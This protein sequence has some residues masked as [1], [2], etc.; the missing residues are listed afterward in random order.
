MIYIDLTDTLLFF[1]RKIR[2]KMPII[3]TGITRVVLNFTYYGLKN[4]KAQ[5][6]YFSEKLQKYASIPN[7]SIL[8]LCNGDYQ[9]LEYFANIDISSRNLLRIKV[10]YRHKHLKFFVICLKYGVELLLRKIKYIYFNKTFSPVKFQDG[11]KILFLCAP[12]ILRKAKYLK[13]IK[14]E[15]KLEMIMLVHDIMPITLGDEYFQSESL[16][17]ETEFFLK[18]SVNFI[19]GFLVATNYW[20]DTLQKYLQ[21]PSDPTSNI[22][23]QVIKF[24][25]G[26]EK[27]QNII[28]CPV[29]GKFIMIVS[30]IEIRKNHIGL[31]KAWKILKDKGVIQNEKLVIIGK[32]GWKI[33]VLQEFL[34]TTHNVDGSVVVLNNVTNEQLVSLYTNCLFTVFPSFAEGYGL[35]IV[36]SFFYGKL[37]LTSNTTAMPEVGGALAEYMDPYNVYDIAEK[38]EKYTTDTNLL[39]TKNKAL[40]NIK[41]TSWEEASELLYSKVLNNPDTLCHGYD[42]AAAPIVP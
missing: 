28:P 34:N 26:N 9:G 14:K 2:K 29:E 24:G 37:C 35:P 42:S 39:N 11:D 10:R 41:T 18:E 15:N 21:K 4:N 23:T 8:K 1:R 12:A 6:V 38:I 16:R 33:G 25:F 27:H 5:C 22:N 31:V 3:P 17:L 36:E 20:R 7:E 40:K 32:W 19:D 30:T 13:Q